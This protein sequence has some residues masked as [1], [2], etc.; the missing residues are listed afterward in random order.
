MKQYFKYFKPINKGVCFEYL[1]NVLLNY[2]KN[3]WEV[4]KHLLYS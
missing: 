4:K 3:S 1:N 2:L